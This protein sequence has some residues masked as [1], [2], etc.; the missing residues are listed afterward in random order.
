MPMKMEGKKAKL[1]HIFTQQIILVRL[2]KEMHHVQ[3]Y[4]SQRK[5]VIFERRGHN[6]QNTAHPSVLRNWLSSELDTKVSFTN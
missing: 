5:S 1:C 2:F 6:S 3:I 4:M